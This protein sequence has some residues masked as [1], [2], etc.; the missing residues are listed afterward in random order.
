MFFRLVFTRHEI[1]HSSIHYGAWTAIQTE[2]E[3]LGELRFNP[4]NAKLNPIC[5][6]LALLEAR[7]ILYVSRIRVKEDIYIY[8]YIYI[9]I[10]VCISLINIVVARSESYKL[11]RVS[12]HV[13]I[14]NRHLHPQNILLQSKLKLL[15]RVPIMTYFNQTVL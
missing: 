15:S 4:L 2:E 6:L 12:L 11:K 14:A 1:Q 8:I 7:H 3:S 9:Y 5:H 10:N 13:F